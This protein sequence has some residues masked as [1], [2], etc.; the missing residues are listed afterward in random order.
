MVEHERGIKQH[1]KLSAE[2]HALSNIVPS[3]DVVLVFSADRTVPANLLKFASSDVAV[4]E[5]VETERN[6]IRADLARTR[7]PLVQFLRDIGA[8]NIEA[9]ENAPAIRAHLPSETLQSVALNTRTDIVLVDTP[10]PDLPRRAYAGH[11]ALGELSVDG[12]NCA[13]GSCDGFGLGVAIWESGF[14]VGNVPG[15]LSL[16]NQRF[17][18]HSQN[19]KNPGQA[20]SGTTP[21]SSGN[22]NNLSPCVQNVCRDEHASLVAASIGLVG[23][24]SQQSFSFPKAGAYWVNYKFANDAGLPGLDW[25]ATQNVLYV[26]RSQGLGN[27]SPLSSTAILLDWY[28]RVQLMTI[29]VATRNSGDVSGG[30]FADCGSFN[31]LCVG[32]AEYRTWN[33]RTGDDLMAA[34]SSWR[35][36]S[37]FGVEW[38]HVVGPWR[39]STYVARYMSEHQLYA[40]KQLYTRV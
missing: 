1:G 29:T 35:N 2:L 14:G 13:Y 17:Y 3:S 19:S 20:C 8:T 40:K 24:Y 12:T 34:W 25:A 23:S 26:N 31:T 27:V 18:I 7:A 32:A 39:R 11:G 6:R 28:T 37:G 5:V 10:I 16:S 36:K 33:A 15:T 9:L 21:C 30:D 22:V 38:P 4:T